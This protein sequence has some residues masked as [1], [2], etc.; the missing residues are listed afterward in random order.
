MDMH[1]LEEERGFLVDLL[2]TTLRE[3]RQEV[4][5]TEGFEFKEILRKKETLLGGL[6]DKLEQPV[7]LIL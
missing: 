1:L 3:L 5:R 2:E 4:H 7:P 6:L